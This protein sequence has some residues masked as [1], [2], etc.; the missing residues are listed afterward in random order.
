MPHDLYDERPYTE[1]AYAE[2][3]PA[4]VAAAARLARWTPPE[5]ARARILELGCGRGGNLL[6]MAA[7][8]PE[9]TFVGVDGSERQIDDARRIARE[10]GLGN[11]TFEHA[12]FETMRLEGASFDYVVCHG[13]LSWIPAAERAPLL[14]IIARV[15]RGDGIA[16]VS[17]NVLPGWYERLAA[18]DWLR[19]A[20]ASLGET[21][22]QAP[23]SLGWLRTQLSG[24]HGDARRRLES[25]AARLRET[26]PAYALHEYLARDH[27][28]LRVT[29]ALGEA[30]AAGLRYLGDAIPAAAA[31]ELLP[32][33]ARL[34]AAG[35]DA[36]AGQQLLDFVQQ[37][38]FRRALLVRAGAPAPAIWTGSP[39]LDAGAI[40]SLH[41]AS[42]LRPVMPLDAAAPQESFADGD[43]V[44]QVADH[45]AR[46]AL[47]A[48]A[49]EAPRAVQFRALAHE[50]LPGLPSED[51]V[52]ALASELFDVWLAVGGIDLYAHDPEVLAAPTERPLACPVA[53]WHAEHGGV[54]TNR[55]HQE[56]LVPDAIVRWVLARLDGTRSESDLAREARSLDANGAVADHELGTLIAASLDRIA[57]CGLLVTK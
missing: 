55:L 5:V 11:V 31:L 28:P 7:G 6:P 17:F 15:L 30:A 25:V 8:L 45:A 16:C 13:V 36:I 37:T 52:G 46:R 40:R 3:H 44:V 34:R 54:V 57:A 19:F 43:R 9:A 12:R 1:H 39:D 53:R 42:R 47:R 10:S 48:L 21:P 2:T 35:L 38:A 18:R 22:E 24:E 41:V 27:H 14:S 33:G 29:D 51:A 56:V 23:E 20:A 49:R 4:R 50:I 32:E 26:D